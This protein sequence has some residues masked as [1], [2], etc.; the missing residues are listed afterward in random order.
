MWPS[1]LVVQSHSTLMFL[2]PSLKSG[3]KGTRLRRGRRL[4]STWS[5][6]YMI[7]QARGL[8]SARSFQS[9]GL[10]LRRRPVRVEM[11]SPSQSHVESEM[12][13]R[14]RGAL[15]TDGRSQERG[16]RERE[17]LSSQTLGLL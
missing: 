15:I 10:R 6:I 2:A 17:R 8:G 4:P 12:A 13:G 5:S 11:P 1:T 3:F 16:E 14:K 9:T 7:F